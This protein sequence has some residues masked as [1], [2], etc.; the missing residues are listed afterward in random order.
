MYP[1][2]Q[3]SE[4]AF[5]NITIT[6]LLGRLVQLKKNKL[7]FCIFEEV[8]YTFLQEHEAQKCAKFMNMLR[9]YPRG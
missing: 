5:T 1:T 3:C 4:R 7:V 9:T 2:F 8:E 6:K